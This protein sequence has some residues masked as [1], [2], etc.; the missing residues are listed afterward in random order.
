MHEVY[1]VGGTANTLVFESTTPHFGQGRPESIYEVIVKA[2]VLTVK[3]NDA[4]AFLTGIK[5]VH[6]Q[7]EKCSAL[8]QVRFV[9]KRLEC[10][11][12]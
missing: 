10:S 3:N 9:R 11:L 6:I 2:G 4:W 7:R 8:N 5:T 1:D 12:F